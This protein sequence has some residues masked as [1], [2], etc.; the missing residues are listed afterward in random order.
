[1]RILAIDPAYNINNKSVTGFALIHDK[2]LVK[3]GFM[4]KNE[5]DD[6][7]EVDFLL[8]QCDHLVVE[9]QYLGLNPQVLMKLVYSRD[10]WIIPAKRYKSI[11]VIFLM[12]PGTW[13]SKVDRTWRRSRGGKKN[14]DE[15]RFYVRQRWAV[16]PQRMDTVAAICIASVYIDTVK[17]R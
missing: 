12:D 4:T 6:P 8:S 10:L 11:K 9:N 1:M 14:Q 13:Q 5:V 17:L 2:I 15:W 16:D 7:S 3:H